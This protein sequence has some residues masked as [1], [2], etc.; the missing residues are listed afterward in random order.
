MTTSS[1]F[2]SSPWNLESEGVLS[3]GQWPFISTEALVEAGQFLAAGESSLLIFVCRVPYIGC[4]TGSL[5][6]LNPPLPSVM[7]DWRIGRGEIPQ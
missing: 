7:S 3:S 5:L 4:F 2:K 1:S 6:C